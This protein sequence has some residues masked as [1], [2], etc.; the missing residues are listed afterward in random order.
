VTEKSDF[1]KQLEM[2]RDYVKEYHE[3]LRQQK[4]KEARRE[5]NRKKYGHDKDE[6]ILT[7]AWKEIMSFIRA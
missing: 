4:A 5:R 3:E 7:F 1:D 2:A 6:G